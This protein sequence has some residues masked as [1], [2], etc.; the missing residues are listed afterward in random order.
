[1]VVADMRQND[2]M[3]CHTSTGIN[4]GQEQLVSGVLDKE[5]FK[6]AVKYRYVA[7]FNFYG[8]R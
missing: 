2:V 4:V 5:K 1:M 7:I 3:M 8:H 6:S